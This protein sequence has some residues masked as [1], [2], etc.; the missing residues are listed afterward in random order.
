MFDAIMN[1]Y[2]KYVWCSQQPSVVRSVIIVSFNPYAMC[3]I[4]WS[5]ASL[6]LAVNY[7]VDYIAWRKLT[8]PCV[9][10]NGSK[11]DENPNGN[12]LTTLSN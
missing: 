1:I 10:R 11:E 5:N 2:T 9:E 6:L 4:Q 8:T 12:A 3:D 7:F